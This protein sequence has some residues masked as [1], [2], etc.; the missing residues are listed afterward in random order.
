MIMRMELAPWERWQRALA[1]DLSSRLTQ[2]ECSAQRWLLKWLAVRDY[3]QSLGRL[4]VPS[5]WAELQDRVGAIAATHPAVVPSAWLQSDPFPGAALLA[6]VPSPTWPRGSGGLGLAMLYG[7]S[8]GGQARKSGGIYYT[9]SALVERIVQRMVPLDLDSSPLRM[10]DPACG[11]GCFLHGAFQRLMARYRQC[12][13]A[14]FPLEPGWTWQDETGQIA[15]TRWGRSQILQRHLYGIDLDAQ[16]AAIARLSLFLAVVAAV[17]PDPVPSVGPVLQAQIQVGNTLLR[18][19]WGSQFPA[20]W[21]AGGFDRVLGNPPYLDAEHMSRAAPQWRTFCSQHYQTAQGNWDSF[22]VFIEQALNLCRVGGQVSLVVPGALLAARYATAT[23]S[24]LAHHRLHWVEDYTQLSPFAAAVYPIAFGVEKQAA[25]APHPPVPYYRLPSLDA[26]GTDLPP[27]GQVWVSA[28]GSAVPWAVV[29]ADMPPDLLARLETQ[30]V[31]LGAIATVQGAATVA[32]A[33]ALQPLLYQGTPDTPGLRVANSGTLDRY[34][35]LWS[36]KPLRYLGQS[37]SCPTVDAVLLQQQCPKR[38]AQARQPKMIV[39]GLTRRLE[40]ALDPG[41][42]YLA[43]KSTTIVMADQLTDLHYY[44]AILN[45]RAMDC[46]LR[47]RF[48]SQCLRDGYLCLG[49]PLLRQL[50]IPSPRDRPAELM[51]WVAQRLALGAA[52]QPEDHPQVQQVEQQLDRAVCDLYGFSDA[53]TRWILG[54]RSSLPNPQ[55]IS[56]PH[57]KPL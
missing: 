51:T 15:L 37:Y 53:E 5:T 7:R 42:H 11:G 34:R 35:L 18:L 21:A 54:S 31:P 17:A 44:L 13:T 19:D 50:P 9:P 6:Q 52:G 27:V 56:S 36:E 4:T 23:R 46:Y 26:A 14:G 25:I 8:P 43:A 38:Y 41:G 40:A 2:P 30:T 47:L 32:E 29:P 48:A 57:N 12:A 24:L 28:V 20:A 39:A 45:S 22:C 33:Y 16:G 1:V 49:P 10:L 3:D 55:F